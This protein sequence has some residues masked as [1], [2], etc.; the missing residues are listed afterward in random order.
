MTNGAVPPLIDCARVLHY[1]VLDHEVH[2]TPRNAIYVDGI[3][4]GAVPRMAVVR[5]LSDAD[6]M[7]FHCD[8]DWTC[9]G[10]SG[11]PSVEDALAYANRRYAGLAGKWREAPYSEAEFAQAV[12]EQHGEERC[13]FCGRHHFQVDVPMVEGDRARICG[14]CIARLH[15]LTSTAGNLPP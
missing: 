2:Y 6:I 10:V 5:N 13:S 1:A 3:E 11:H 8:D 4:L 14:D 9:L 12:A 15:A 7:L